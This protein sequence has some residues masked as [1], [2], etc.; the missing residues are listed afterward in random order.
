LNDIPP[1][2]QA[3]EAPPPVSSLSPNEVD[4]FYRFHYGPGLDRIF[5]TTWYTTRGVPQLRQDPTLVDFVSQ[6]A[7][8]MKTPDASPSASTPSLE[9]RLIWQLAIMP[10]S[11][12]IDSDTNGASNDQLTLD[13]L[14]RI[15]TLEHLLTGQFL[16]QAKIPAPP[17]PAQQNDRVIGAEMT[18]WHQLGIFT[19]VPDDDPSNSTNNLRAIADSLAAMRAIL[20]MIES[21]DVLYSFAVARHIGGRMPEYH[22][23]HPLPASISAMATQDPN[24]EGVKLRIAHQFVEAESAKGTSQVVQRLC[25]MAMRSWALEKE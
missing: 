6:C 14:P 1:Q 8:Q 15:D 12:T 22:P 11:A 7:E 19:S 20:N 21:R 10:R 17:T 13:L 25:A 3:R 24:D 18:F 2:Y 5:E 9:A 4:D 23:R 16:P